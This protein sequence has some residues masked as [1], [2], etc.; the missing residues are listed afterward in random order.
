LN[1]KFAGIL[2]TIKYLCLIIAVFSYLEG[3]AQNDT[4]ALHTKAV[5]G[6]MTG[7]I[8]D[9]SKQRDVIDF[10]Q[11]I[12]K[13]NTPVNSRLHAKKLVFSVVPAIGY[14][15]TTGFAADITANMAFYTNTNHTNNLSAIDLETV[16]DTKNQKII[17]SR[18]EIWYDNNNY[19]LITD[20]RWEE[21]PI[22]TY[23]LGTT[24]TTATTDPLVYNYIRTYGTF[25]KKVTGDFYAGLGYNLDHHY[26]ITQMGNANNTVSDYTKYGFN[27]TSTSSGIVLNLL[28][29][30]RK[31]PINPLNGGYASVIYRDNFTFLGSDS[32]WQELSMDFRRYF[33]VSPDNNNIL[34]FWSILAFTNGNVPYLDLPYTASDTYDNSGRGYPE[35]R[36]RGRNELYLEG[37]YRFGIL[38]NGLLG[39]VVFTNAE[40]FS[41][42]ETNRFV[43]IAPAAG[44]GLRLK[45][46]KHSNTNVCL[47]YAYGINSRGIFVN[48]GEDF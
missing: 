38:K 45:I 23:G 16:Y 29:D 42:F 19:K 32:H 20:V 44:T 41:E 43:K 31:N 12:L 14:S 36:F 35:Q 11:K 28:F 10:L 17:A 1:K 3:A 18:S 39:G 47:D 8:V 21:Y 5:P 25:F 22:D 40:S 37:E 15:L 9:S 33:R 4:S 24:A 48:L 6:K 30:N 46:N 13:K 26:N 27:S 34:A 7:S 2:K